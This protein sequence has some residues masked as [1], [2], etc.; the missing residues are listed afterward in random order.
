MEEAAS[1]SRPHLCYHRV[2]NDRDPFFPSMRVETFEMQMR[3]VTRRYKI[4]S[5]SDLITHLE[6]DSPETV[7]AVTFDDGYRDNYQNAFP[8]LQRYGV[9]ATVFLTTGCLDSG[10]PPGSNGLPRHKGD[11]A[12]RTWTSKLTCRGVSGCALRRTPPDRHG[13]NGAAPTG[14]ERRAP[15]APGDNAPGS[16]GTRG[17]S[18]PER[19]ADVGPG[20][21]HEAAQ[22]RFRRPHGHASLTLRVPHEQVVWEIRNASGESKRNFR[23]RSDT[24]PIR[25]GVV[26]TLRHLTKKP[27]GRRATRPL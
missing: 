4:V 26:K 16:G 10:E 25:T 9:P 1:A 7:F 17:R 19:H 2:N 18:G 14:V 12:K 15:E 23:R 20:S 22:C 11:F 24:S 27:Y 5:L 6:S 13:I 8:I 3:F 21:S